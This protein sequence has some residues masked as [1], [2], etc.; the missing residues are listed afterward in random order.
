MSVTYT[1][2]TGTLKNDLKAKF[3]DIKNTYIEPAFRNSGIFN[4]E[5]ALDATAG[6]CPSESLDGLQKFVSAMFC[7]YE[8]FE[9]NF[10]KTTGTIDLNTDPTTYKLLYRDYSPDSNTNGYTEIN[11]TILLDSNRG[12]IESID[13]ILDANSDENTPRD[14]IEINFS[15]FLVSTGDLIKNLNNI[16]RLYGILE[17]T[18]YTKYKQLVVSPSGDSFNIKLYST[19]TSSG[20]I[21]TRFELVNSNTVSTYIQLFDEIRPSTSKTER[22]TTAD[23]DSNA[24]ITKPTATISPSTL[25][26]P[27]DVYNDTSVLFV[28]NAYVTNNPV[29]QY[30]S[31]VY[32]IPTSATNNAPTIGKYYTVNMYIKTRN[33][34]VSPAT[35]ISD[36]NV[37]LRL[38][39]SNNNGADTSVTGVPYAVEKTIRINNQWKFVSIT[40]RFNYRNPTDFKVKLEIQTLHP[41]VITSTYKDYNFYVTGFRLQERDSISNDEAGGVYTDPYFDDITNRV[42]V[43]RLLLMYEL[44]ATYYIAAKIYLIYMG[45]SN[46]GLVNKAKAISYLVH[47]YLSNINNN[48]STISPTLNNNS[49][50]YLSDVVN[51]Q[52][53][54]FYDTSKSVQENTGE[55]NT[56]KDV[57]KGNVDLLNNE[58]SRKTTNNTFMILSIVLACIVIVACCVAYFLPIERGTKIV[59]ALGA[60]LTSIILIIVFKLIYNTNKEYFQVPPPSI[61]TTYTLTTDQSEIPATTY[62]YALNFSSKF[63]QN[64]IS[65]TLMNQTA[66]TYSAM[67][68]S[69]AK[70]DNY[71]KNVR[72]Q[73]ESSSAKITEAKGARQLDTY[74]KR[75]RVSFFINLA[76]ILSLTMSGSIMLSAIP[77]IS[78]IIIIAGCIS[79]IFAILLYVLDVSRRVRTSGSKMYWLQPVTTGF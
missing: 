57:V 52:T 2:D 14:T 11:H 69:L 28:T 12:P 46:R 24:T 71:F 39:F 51:D 79:V 50:G 59:I 35:D 15:Q 33:S 34:Q 44:I 10:L 41:G 25:S 54:A 8:E 7:G 20:D 55:I 9:Q 66:N 78:N 74:T 16:R 70:E 36:F 4:I 47:E 17:E 18:N 42:V 30:S 21:N 38:I 23:V 56:L 49:L 43:R 67:N 72:S 40:R 65:I 19:A 5:S 22:L 60:M 61:G 29:R 27:S 1:T 6:S 76:I 48:L 68:Y 3:L 32:H 37:K 62:N 53:R 64:T 13:A 31:I 73:L 63:L 45:N 75:A 77:I 26:L 58:L